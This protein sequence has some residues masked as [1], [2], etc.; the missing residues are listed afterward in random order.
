ME[1]A[2]WHGIA[3]VEFKVEEDGSAHL[4]EVNT[5]FWGSLQLSIDAGVDFPWLL[6]QVAIGK[7]PNSVTQYQTGNR[8]RWLLGDLDNL[9]ITVK[10]K[11]NIITKI[12][13]ILSF[14]N[15]FGPKT[16]HEVNRW[17]DLAPF[18]WELR[19][20]IKDLF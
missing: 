17:G 18:W 3:M 1:N 19:K 7:Q 2:K 9:Y 4:I 12:Q 20:Y 16:R 5:R 6:Y 13:A 15:P 11:S 14:L 10:G 8:L